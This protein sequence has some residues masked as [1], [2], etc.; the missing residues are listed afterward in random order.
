MS[1]LL[2][3]LRSSCEDDGPAFWILC[4]THVSSG[5]YGNIDG[6]PL[7]RLSRALPPLIIPER[8]CAKRSVCVCVCVC[9][10]CG[11]GRVE[12]PWVFACIA[13]NKA[14]SL[15]CFPFPSAMLSLLLQDTVG[16]HSLTTTLA[17]EGVIC[18]PL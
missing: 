4:D 5:V 18:T 9:T 10:L 12:A 3:R 7:L 15:A 11:I 14:Q 8:V 6:F 17:M 2:G 16:N 13:E 1:H